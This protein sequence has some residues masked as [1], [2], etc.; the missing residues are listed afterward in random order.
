M[1]DDRNGHSD[2][3]SPS[4]RAPAGRPAGTD[5]SA[6][7]K[8]L[9]A[10]KNF[11]SGS[12]LIRQ[13]R[14]SSPP[15]LNAEAK[16][17]VATLVELEE[18]YERALKTVTMAFQPIVRANTLEVFGYE[19]LMRLSDPDLPHPGA[20]LDA[21]ERLHRLQ[22]LG[23]TL[24]GLAAKLFAEEPAER[25]FLF[26]NVTALDLQDKSLCSRFG[27][28]ARIADRVVLE[29]TERASFN[30]LRDVQFRVAEL[31]ELG[32]RIAIDDLGAGHERM[33]QF[34]PGD[35]DLVKLDISLV[36]DIHTHPLK[37][38]LTRS[39]TQLCRDN[40]ILVIGEGV[41]QG[42]EAEVLT[43]LGCDL[44]QGFYFARPGHGFP[45]PS[46]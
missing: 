10:P 26:I 19:A 24:R 32:F 5:P 8:E 9:K 20:M 29:V 35:T 2:R 31:R 4:D 27:P 23:R 25:G 42:E 13:S 40:E 46:R 15:P 3:T 1:K 44:L 21:A 34:E 37:Q 17:H 7:P 6:E 38:A 22:P 14:E 43:E 45:V 41:E 11:A 39:I 36:R 18:Q 12:G 16:K 33:T 30:D 28:L